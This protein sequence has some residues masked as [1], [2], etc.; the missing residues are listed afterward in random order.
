MRPPPLLSPVLA[1]VLG[2]LAATAIAQPRVDVGKREFQTKCAACHGTDGKGLGSSAEQLKRTLPDLTTMAARNGGV[3]PVTQTYVMIEGAGGGHGTREMPVWG[4]AYTVQ[5]AEEL[6]DL[7]YNQAMF[8]RSRIMAL[9]E[10][11]ASIQAK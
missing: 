2:A 3:F 8:V 9:I 10:Y 11:L 4:L 1:C 6:P 7:P 5:A